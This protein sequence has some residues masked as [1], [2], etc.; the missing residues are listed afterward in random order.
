[1][2]GAAALRQRE[3]EGTS[4]GY[5]PPE[6]TS[7]GTIEELTLTETDIKSSGESKMT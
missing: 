4:K 3:A 1:M 2:T 7:I 6:V 5:E